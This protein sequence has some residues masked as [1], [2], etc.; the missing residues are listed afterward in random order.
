VASLRAPGGVWVVDGD[1]DDPPELEWVLRGTGARLLMNDV[2][3]TRAAGRD[4]TIGGIRVNW[5]TREARSV[6]ERLERAPERL[7]AH[8]VVRPQHLERPAAGRVARPVREV[9]LP[10]PQHERVGEVARVDRVGVGAYRQPFKPL[11]DTPS[12]M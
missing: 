11:R 4:V 9:L 8:E 1:S 10:H 5:R 3:R 12:M 2:V 7:P 6:Y